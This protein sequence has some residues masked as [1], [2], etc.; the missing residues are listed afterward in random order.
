MREY[1]ID[2]LLL[3]YKTEFLP[4]YSDLVGYIADKPQEI[5][6][7]IENILSH[8]LQYHNTALTEEQKREN[9]TKA[10]NH[11]QR[12]TLDCYKL[13]WV[14]LNKR[15]VQIENDKNFYKFCTKLSEEEL[16]H[17][18]DVFKRSAQEARSIEAQNIGVDVKP[19]L[20]G[21]KEAV[22]NGMNIIESIDSS[23]EHDLVVL[24]HKH[25]F[26]ITL[27]DVIVA[28][29]G[30]LIIILLTCLYDGYIHPLFDAII[31]YIT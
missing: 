26:K 5:L 10:Y 24:K 30:G 18:I 25:K 28:A 19:S 27:R 4:A 1:T 22:Q 16:L 3:F 2:D 6:L 29:I 15:I 9:I 8:L 20:E 7:S 13:L 21:Y 11:L 17:S 31:K 23:K 12:A 14:S